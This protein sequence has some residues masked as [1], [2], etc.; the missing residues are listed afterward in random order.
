MPSP[1][2]RCPAGRRTRHAGRARSPNRNISPAANQGMPARLATCDS[3]L[4]RAQN[5]PPSPDN[6]NTPR[7]F[8]GRAAS[9]Q[10]PTHAAAT[11]DPS[12]TLPWQ[13]SEGSR[14]QFVHLPRHAAHPT[15]AHEKTTW[16]WNHP[17]PLPPLG[18]AGIHVIP[19]HN[20][21]GTNVGASLATPSSQNGRRKRRPYMPIRMQ[22]GIINKAV[23]CSQMFTNKC[24]TP[25]NNQ[26][27]F[28]SKTTTAA[29]ARTNSSLLTLT[30]NLNLFPFPLTFNPFP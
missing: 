10:P 1:Q 4:R 9:R 21:N 26:R 20:Q 29:E 14:P 5:R 25:R 13:Q 18:C 30:L 28:C 19:T 12:R 24:F 11:R 16:R 2:G 27:V 8:A 7:S 15:C 3:C 23:R 22:D 17:P 6:F